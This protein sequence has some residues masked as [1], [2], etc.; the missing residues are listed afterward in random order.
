M[1]PDVFQQLNQMYTPEEQEKLLMDFFDE[2]LE[3]VKPGPHRRN[4]P[5]E[6]Q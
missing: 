3:A 6:R 2:V 1:K 4:T 5:Y